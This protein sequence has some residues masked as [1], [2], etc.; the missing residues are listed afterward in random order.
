MA[1]Y[2]MSIGLEDV[3][4]LDRK[5][6]SLNGEDAWNAL[7]I[8]E[9]PL[10]ADHQI[11]IFRNLK[12]LLANWYRLWKRIQ[13]II[14]RVDTLSKEPS[15]T[16]PSLTDTMAIVCENKRI[17]VSL[18][19]SKRVVSVSFSIFLF[20]TLWWYRGTNLNPRIELKIPCSWLLLRRNNARA[21]ESQGWRRRRRVCNIWADVPKSKCIY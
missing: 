7:E 21:K 4:M 15:W 3:W 2:G 20:L 16:M 10:Y 9:F 12:S 14:C 13:R 5:V 1:F 11:E 8:A 17:L 19:G 6:W 18:N